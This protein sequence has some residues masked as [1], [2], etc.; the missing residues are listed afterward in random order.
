MA[1]AEK[2][3]PRGGTI[4]KPANTIDG[5]SN[6]IF[7]ATQKK[8]KKTPKS[9]DNH[10]KGLNNDEGEQLQSSYAETLTFDTLQDDMLVMGV[11]KNTSATS[12]DIALPGR[13]T[14][15]TLVADISDAYSRVAKAAMDGD[16]SEYNALTEL[17][18]VGRIVYGRAI[19]TE[20]FNNS[21]TRLLLNLKPVDVHTGL[22]HTNIK[23]GFIFTGAIHEIQE[24]GYVIETG[25]EGLHAFLAMEERASKELR[26]MGELV[27]LKVKQIH[28]T[29]TQSTCTCV[30]VD[31]AG[32]KIKSQNECN[33]DYILPGSILKFKVGKHIKNG[34]QGTIMHESFT[35]YVNEH[36]LAE[37]LHVPEDYELN[38]EYEARVLYIMPL[39][40]LVYLTLNLNIEVMNHL[41]PAGGED[42]EEDQTEQ[43]EGEPLKRGSVVEK[44]KVMRLGTG[45]VILLLNKKFKG[46]ISYGSIKTNYK[47]NYDNDEVLAK[48]AR[49]S[50]HKVRI[51][52]Y[53][54]IEALYYC[55]DDQ[56]VINEKY[57][58]LEDIEPGE[59]VTAKIVKLDEKIGGYDV[60]IGNLKGVIEKLFLAPNIKY[61][62]GLRLRC[63]IVDVNMDRKICYLT[64]RAE[65]LDKS[66]KVLTSL[67]A[68]QVGNSYMGTIVKCDPNYVLVKFFNGI[69]GVLH[70]HRLIG[71]VATDPNSFVEGQ[72]TKFRIFSRNDEQ[73]AL[74]LPE[75]KFHVGE[76]CPTEVTNTLDAGL[77]I[78]ITYAGDE[79]QQEQEVE[80]FIGLIP[81]RLLS[82]HLDLLEAQRRIH[83][84]GSKIKAACITQNIFS[85]RDVPYF[86]ENLTKNWQTVQV[87][88]VLRAYVKN[89]TDKVID[90]LVP[91]RNYNKLVKVHVKM[92]RLNAVRHVPIALAPEQVLYVKVLSKEVET[93]TLT[94][95]AKLT[96]VWKGQLNE[97]AQFVE[98]YLKEVA[99]IRKALKKQNAPIA[100]NIIGEQVNVVFK[101]VHPETNDWIYTVEGSSLTA[102]LKYHLAGLAPKTPE[103]GKKQ[104][105]VVLWI[106]YASDVLFISITKADIEHIV[107]S[108]KIAEN[109]AGKAGMKAKVLLKL[110]SIYI[111]SLKKGTN[112]LV[113]CPVRLHHNDVENSASVGLNEGEFCNLA[114]IHDKLPIAVP[115]AV[116]KLWRNVKRPKVDKDEVLIETKKPKLE[117][118]LLKSKSSKVNDKTSVVLNGK[119]PQP[120]NVKKVKLKNGQKTETPNSKKAKLEKLEEQLLKSKSSKVNDK[121]S[122]VLNGKEPQPENVKKVKLKNGQKTETPNNKKAK[123]ENGKV[124]QNAQLFFE[125]KIPSKPAG[126]VQPAPSKERLPGVSSF[127]T[128]DLSTLNGNKQP[129]SSDDDEETPDNE[130]NAS[131]RKRLSAKEKAKAQ[132]KE[133]Q[134][135]R[136]IEERNADPTQ[137]PETIDQFERL[138]LAEPNNSKSWIEYIAFL[139][140][141]TE[142]EKARAVARRAIKTIAFRESGELLN[143]W[144]ALLNLELIYNTNQFNDVLKE[145]L[146]CNEPIDIYMRTVDILKRAQRKEQLIDMLGLMQ[147]KFK[148]Q[149]KVWRLIADAYF[150]LD[151]KDRVQPL[152]QRALAVLPNNDHINCIVAFANLYAKNGDNDMA[153]TLLD[154]IVTSYPKRIDIWVLYVDM[155]IKADL[156]DSARNVLARAVLH[157]LRPNKMVVI[158]KKFLD[159]ELKYGTDE[160]ATRVKQ[161]AEDYVKNYNKS[162][163]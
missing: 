34:L 32:L 151:M 120:E 72:T 143:V 159:F 54:V 128:T 124:Q 91:V 125:D 66:V 127:W 83:A 87:G 160:N 116:W 31:Q 102:I 21:R 118:Q 70:M 135:L 69:K 77:E 106:D 71:F 138:V 85:L 50:K 38:A 93:H 1:L 154:D 25:I 73:I 12:L 13:L 74:T 156:I 36:H 42:E 99:E 10:L 53:D 24:H 2:C 5:T 37:A 86:S 109:L 51:L 113:V 89:A 139:L 107:T 57:F 43:V 140:S 131:K 132:I 141:N 137:R 56:N 14:A 16:L 49:K 100:K 23:K 3:F 130:L 19:K 121:T 98:S 96:D 81:L 62:V 136:E 110:E 111:C 163:S 4:H 90:L 58:A 18:A 80:E 52:G 55:T 105:A 45:G 122:V 28:H 92:L 101:G 103:M 75:D 67:Q 129:E 46:L 88:D 59:V 78:K 146:T 119:E 161:M 147:R 95:S 79:E 144:S 158:F 152:L 157:K 112:P 149:L 33:L 68:A 63:R 115:E 84:A 47:G 20:K 104:Q 134:R 114:I 27:S 8:T 6:I 35:A 44:A 82:D 117:E 11:V 155:L 17:F 9:K 162:A 40:K 41:F 29:D 97:T 65:Y 153:Q 123:L 126:P 133:E 61:D 60:K 26:H 7:G 148:T 76:I 15:R 64:N 22:L 94:V 142:I 145:A 30:A 108:T 48:Y 39:T 150:S